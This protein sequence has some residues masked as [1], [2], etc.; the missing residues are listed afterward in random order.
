MNRFKKDKNT[1]F[2]QLAAKLRRRT[3]RLQWCPGAKKRFAADIPE[4]P[5][6]EL[7]TAFRGVI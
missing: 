1:P 4:Q 7:D 5:W 2:G 6:G 3:K